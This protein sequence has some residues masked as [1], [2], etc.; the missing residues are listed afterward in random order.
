MADRI[1]VLRRGVIEQQGR[2]IDLYRD[3]DNAFVAGFI[4]SPKMNFF[5]GVLRPDG[6]IGLAETAFAPALSCSPGGGQEV[7]IGLRPEHFEIGTEAGVSLTMEID[8][9]ENLGGNSIWHGHLSSGEKLLV[10]RR[11]YHDQ[12][13]GTSV[14]VSFRRE[15][16]LIFDHDGKRLR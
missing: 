3:P 4:G 7:T 16:A 14:P 15:N 6:T 12:G 1:V 5:K 10:E 13:L 11:G 8:L 9:I 2:P